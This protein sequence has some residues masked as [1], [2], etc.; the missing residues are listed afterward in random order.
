VLS[1]PS[2]IRGVA[3]EAGFC[4]LDQDGV[5][6]L[7]PKSAGLAKR[8]DPLH[9]AVATVTLGSLAALAPRHPIAQRPL[10]PVIGRLHTLDLNEHPKRFHLPQEPPD[11]ASRRILAS[12][13]LADQMREA[14]IP[15]PPV[16]HSGRGMGHMTQPPQLPGHLSTEA[17]DF[18]L[19]TF[20]Q[21]LGLAY[22]VGQAALPELNPLAIEPVA[23][24]DQDP[25]PVVHQFQEG[26]RGI[27][28]HPQP[29]QPTLLE[30]RGLLHMVHRRTP[31]LTPNGLVVRPDGLRDPVDHLLD[32]PIGD[33]YPQNPS[34][35]IPHC[36]AAFALDAS[37]L[38]RK[39]REPGA[40][41]PVSACGQL[42]L[43][44]PST[45]NAAPLVEHKVSDLHLDLRKLHHLMDMIGL[46][47]CELPPSTRALHREH[48]LA[49][50]GLKH[51][52]PLTP[53]SLLRPPLLASFVLGLPLVRAVRTGGLVRVGGVRADHCPESLH[54]P[55]ELLELHPKSDH[56]QHKEAYSLGL[57]KGWH[58]I[59]GD[60][61]AGVC[62]GI[63]QHAGF[64]I[65]PLFHKPAYSTNRAKVQGKKYA[66]PGG[67]EIFITS[68][69]V[70]SKRLPP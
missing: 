9:P 69:H 48:G 42:G 49:P 24:A 63:L 4:G 12:L 45:L 65:G 51:P 58:S 20:G 40:V 16:T 5:G 23:V 13:M 67:R 70:T 54:L 1:E 68:E 27:G 35:Q 37:Q 34:E 36:R 17:R 59:L 21:P 62:L 6:R 57:G 31:C 38:R 43:L 3:L 44:E 25:H 33:R 11:K 8:E 30:P 61:T 32:G 66:K 55:S 28:H 7:S 29:L 26:L 53:M 50:C 47:L 41:A 14:G 22:Q 64:T 52:L 15:S 10:C 39:R 60:Q 19:G 18:G 2:E 56:S 46:E